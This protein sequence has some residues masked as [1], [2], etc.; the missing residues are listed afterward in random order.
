[1]GIFH[2]SSVPWN[3]KVGIEGLWS[4]DGFLILSS[5]V[6]CYA[7]TLGTYRLWFHRLAGFPGPWY[8]A[9]SYW[10]EFYYDVILGGQYF[11]VIDELHAQYGPVVRVNPNEVHFDDAEFIDTLFPLSGRKTDKPISTGKRTGTPE[12]LVTTVS[13]D[14]HRR[15]RN[16]V[17]VF[18]SNNSIRRLEPIIQERL[19]KLLERISDPDV[20]EKPI[21]MHPLFRACTNDV[22]TTYAFGHSLGLLE[23]PDLGKAYYRSSDVFFR[24]SHLFGHFHF[25]ADLMQLIPLKLVPFLD[26]RMK[27]LVEKQIY[28]INKVREIRGDAPTIQDA[29]IAKTKNTIFEGIVRAGLPGEDLTDKRLAAEAQLI[30][31][32][33]EGTT[34][35]TL[36]AATYELLANPST[37]ERLRE[38]L[39]AAIPDNTSLPTFAQVEGL[40]Y[41]NAVIQETV[42]LHPGVMARQARIS[43]DVPVVYKDKYVVPPGTLFSMSPL[44]THL[45][46]KEFGPDNYAF[47]PQRWIDDPSI[48]RAFLGFAR[49][50][51]NCVGMNMARKEMTLV[52]ATLFRRYE[53]YRGQ[54]GPTME[55]FDTERKRD[56]D[57]NF[58]Y[59]IPVPAKGSCGLRVVFRH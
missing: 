2:L 11:K 6:L 37:L 29:S 14:A 23:S 47:R 39:V 7:V 18:F 35:Y 49:G 36:M 9:I 28:W 4:W 44:T 45:T 13:H 22:I 43:P 8:I 48:G 40:P 21:E 17:N 32:A 34:A 27:E 41:L 52:L 38:E 51:R 55:L 53:L 59:I 42:R 54:E 1:M 5:L 15:R 56:V 46:A 10:P 26:P 33:G 31:F 20:K 24:L 3:F 16:A 57:P 58:D 12:S 30:I 50:S 19:S 25:L